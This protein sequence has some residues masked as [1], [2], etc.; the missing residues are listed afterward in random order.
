MT[1]RIALI[2]SAPSS[3]KRAPY[4][5]STWLVYA[6]SP[7]AIAHVR[8]VDTF[9]ELHAWRPE[10]PCCETN[11]VKRLQALD[12]PIFMV[13]PVPELPNSKPFPKEEVMG[14][15]W[16][17][18]RN[19][20]GEERRLQFDPNSFT[21]SLSWMIAYAITQQPDEIGL[22]GVDMAADE[23]IYSQQKAG[24]LSLLHIAK[25]IGIKVTVPPESDLMRPHPPYGYQEHDHMWIKLNEREKEITQRINECVSVIRGKEQEYQFLLGARDNNAYQMRTWV[26]DGQ[27]LHMQ[28]SQP[29]LINDIAQGEFVVQ[30]DAPAKKKRGRPKKAA[31]LNGHSK[32]PMVVVAEA[33]A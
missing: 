7:G 12:C 30:A 9:F 10:N 11:Y 14:F 25:Q 18:V 8:R 24:C 21:S 31:A 13:D 33:S 2:G 20:R 27:A 32:S 3:V 16:G 23:E 29:E 19:A 4:D 26:A 1:K 17:T 5:D 22:W 28:F 6:C 15:S